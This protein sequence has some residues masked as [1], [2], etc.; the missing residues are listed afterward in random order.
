ML[1]KIGLAAGSD[2]PKIGDF[3]KRENGRNQESPAKNPAKMAESVL[4]AAM[5][6]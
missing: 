6:P 2:F 1:S 4:A 5:H 3:P